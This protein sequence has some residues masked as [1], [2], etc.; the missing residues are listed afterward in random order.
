MF[1][2]VSSPGTYHVVYLSLLIRIMEATPKHLETLEKTV[3]SLVDSHPPQRERV[4]VEGKA[5]RVSGKEYEKKK[6]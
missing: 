5:V 4:N 1:L 3:P 6:G 2:R